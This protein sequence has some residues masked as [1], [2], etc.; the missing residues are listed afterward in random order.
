[1]ALL[2]DYTW[3]T[4]Y[5]SDTLS[6]IKDFYEP[7]LSCAVRYERSTGFFSARILTLAARGIEGLIRNNG[8]M[9]LIIGCTLGESEVEAIARGEKLREVVDRSLSNFPLIPEN[10]EEADALELLSWMVAQGYLEVKL[11]LPCGS[12]RQPIPVQGIFHEKAGI[13][14]DKAGNRLAFNGS[15][16]ETAK[17]WAGNWESFH[18]FTDWSGTKLHL[19]EEERGFAKLWTN[20]AKRCLV[21]DVPTAVKAQLLSYLPPI[22]QK[23]KRLEGVE[24]LQV[25]TQHTVGIGTAGATTPQTDEKAG[26]EKNQPLDLQ[27]QFKQIWRLIQFGPATPGQGDRVGEATCGITPYPHQVKAFQRLYQNWPPK[28]LIADEVGLGKT[29]QAGLLIRQAWLAGKGK[30]ILILAPKAVLTQWQIELREKFNLNIPIYDGKTLSWYDCPALRVLGKPIIKPVSRQEWHKEPIVITSSYLMRR[31]DRAKELLSE[32][33]P[34]DLVFLDEAHHAR[35]QGVSGLQPKGPNQLLR[36]MQ[37]LKHRTQGLVLLTATPMQVS[38]IEVWDLLNL[39]GLPQQWDLQSFRHFFDYAS[40]LNPSHD[41]FEFMARLFRAVEAQFDETPLEVAQKFVSGSSK[42]A[43]KKVLQALRDEATLPRKQLSNERRRDAIAIMRSNTPVNRLISR[44]TRE[45]LRRYYEAGKISSR[46]ATRIVEDEFVTLTAAERKVYEAV[47]DYISTTYNNASQADKNAVGFV[48]TIYRR[49]L[50]SSFAALE[51]TLNQRIDTIKIGNDSQLEPNEENLSD[52]ENAD[53]AMDTEE[54]SQLEIKALKAE[55]VRDLEFL[56]VQVK[57]LPPDTKAQIIRQKIQQLRQQNYQQIIVFTQ[58]T[59]TMDFLRQYLVE[60]EKYKIL[61]FSGRG[62]ELG[63]SNGNWRVISRDDTKRIFREGKADILL[64]TDAAAEGLNFQFCGALINYDMPWNPMRVE[65]RIGRI[66]R[67]GQAFENIKI[68]NLHYE[69]TVETDVYLALRERIGLF[70]QYVG[71]LQPILATLPRSITNAALSSRTQNEEQRAT[72]V[73]ELDSSIRQAKEDSFDLDVITEADLEELPRPEPL[74]DL[75]TLDK[76]LQSPA[77]LPPGLD[78]QLMQDGEYKFS[79]P[80]MK[81]TLRV[82][83]KANYFDEHPDS[84]ELWSPG[85]PLFPVVDG[86]E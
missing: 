61:C 81:E 26:D 54:A 66:D 27:E 63:L 36:L 59:D 35:R 67:L 11:A 16:N 70:S 78:V 6:L 42:L 72:L 57:Q 31:A 32:A 40:T 77:L 58:Y 62:G 65:Q 30:R 38:P 8:T 51:H 2:T 23:P 1:M 47:E 19:D 49:R 83:T 73:S 53:E 80:G 55:E 69:N 75:K 71:K 68:I 20:Q 13:I 60:T 43:T 7:A 21:I 74:Y 33:E 3:A 76:I 41:Q 24:E 86:I 10:I 85:S 45:L 64:C 18:V 12:E 28:L 39:L 17:G 82:T 22:D 25:S 48:M 15:V 52:D 5:D 84:T 56:L 34:Y 9:R 46:I 14:E 79:M 44:H 37:Q 29:I 50:A 4:K